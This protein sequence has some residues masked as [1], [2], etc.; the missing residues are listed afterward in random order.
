M[1]QIFQEHKDWNEILGSK[2]IG[3]IN[4]E[5]QHG[6]TVQLIQASEALHEK[7]YASIADMIVERNARIVLLS[8]PSSSGKT[9]SAK[10][11][12]VQLRVAKKRPLTIELDNY[13]VDREHTP[14][15]ENGEYDFEALEAIDIE[16]L[17]DNLNALLAG[18]EVSLPHFDFITGTRQFLEKDRIR[19]G[20]DDILIMEGIHGLNPALLRNV[21]S[22]K[23]FR[24]YA[25]ALTSVSIDEN[26]RIP[27][28]DN[29]LIR[30]IIRDAATR[31]YSAADTIGRWQSVRRGEDRNIFPWQEN[32]DVMFNSSLLYE[33]CVLRKYV[34]PLLRKVP[35]CRQEYTEA[36][37]L[38]KFIGYFEHIEA[39]DEWAI[40]PTSVLREFIGKSSFSY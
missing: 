40:P 3:S 5:I 16:L 13:F 10:R 39:D 29:R 11:L 26:N 7:K 38:L 8:G 36:I 23:V 14:R 15:D 21:D 25:S 24:V 19:I 35:P 20:A 22:D 30:R 32:A 31:G 33:L 27:T 1:L 37:R 17:N 28:T 18:E 12:A 6:R 4:R 34:E 9:T 2:S